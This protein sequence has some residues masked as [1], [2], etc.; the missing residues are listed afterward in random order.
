MSLGTTSAVNIPARVRD[1]TSLGQEDIQHNPLLHRHLV[2]IPSGITVEF[3]CGGDT[4]EESEKRGS[5]Y[6]LRGVSACNGIEILMG[7]GG[8]AFGDC[9]R[10]CAWVV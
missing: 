3:L 8:K 5:S 4:T 6:K 7:C 1:M 10:G 9:A 2:H